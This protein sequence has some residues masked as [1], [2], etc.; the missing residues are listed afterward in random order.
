[1]VGVDGTGVSFY[2]SGEALLGSCGGGAG[3]RAVSEAERAEEGHVLGA[4]DGH[5]HLGG[6]GV[7]GAGPALG[8]EEGLGAGVGLGRVELAGAALAVDAR[9]V[10]CLGAGALAAAP[11]SSMARSLPLTSDPPSKTSP[12]DGE[13]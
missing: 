7:D 2:R 9:D 11:A 10:E 5:G 3:D 4:G 12:A 8:G 6:I 13:D 1:M